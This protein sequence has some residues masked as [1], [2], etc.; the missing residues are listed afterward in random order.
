MPN[1]RTN[2]EKLDALIEALGDSI[3]EASDEEIL[4]ELRLSGIDMNAEAARLKAMLMRTVTA[5]RK[6]PLEVARAAYN[7]QLEHLEKKPYRIPET[8]T[9]RRKL[10]S[11]FTQR[12]QFAEFVTAQYRNI[13][14]LT[15]NDIESYLEDL[16]DLGILDQFSDD[17]KDGNQ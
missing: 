13:K 10:F 2:E 3:L 12:P 8:T 14:E 1:K 17:K 11:L 4:E 5:F 15:D 9:E 16:A 6:R 7:L